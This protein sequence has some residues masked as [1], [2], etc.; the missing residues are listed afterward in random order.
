[1]KKVI[2][3]VVIVVILAAI[4]LSVKRFIDERHRIDESLAQILPEISSFCQ[5]Q[6]IPVP[7]EEFREQVCNFQR[8]EN[9]E[10][11]QSARSSRTNKDFLKKSQKILERNT[12]RM[13][14]MLESYLNVPRPK[15]EVAQ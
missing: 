15:E 1:M 12:G 11:K 5:D 13:N 4:G 14:E 10:L 2:L 9:E 6:S 3:A 8:E 7:S